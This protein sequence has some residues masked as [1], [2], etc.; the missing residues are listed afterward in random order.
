MRS[1]EDGNKSADPQNHSRNTLAFSRLTLLASSF[2]S[3]TASAAPRLPLVLTGGLMHLC[4]FEE[5][6]KEFLSDAETVCPPLEG[7]NTSSRLHN[8]PET[9]VSVHQS[10]T[11][12]QSEQQLK[13]RRL[14]VGLC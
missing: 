5:P 8:N 13:W 4:T 1:P 2:S 10:S 11:Q 12:S 9:H 3:Q 14:T 7:N 6:L